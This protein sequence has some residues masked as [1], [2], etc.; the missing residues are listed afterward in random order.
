M[1]YFVELERQYL[2]LWSEV[3][4]GEGFTGLGRQILHCTFGSVLTDPE[5]G[6]LLRSLLEKEAARLRKQNELLHDKAGKE[7]RGSRNGR[8]HGAAAR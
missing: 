2:G 4:V 6:P 7:R 5:L 1:Y 3:P 8:A